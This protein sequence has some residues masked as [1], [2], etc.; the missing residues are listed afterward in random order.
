M[1]FVN[2]RELKDQFHLRLG[3][4][5]HASAQLDFNVGLSMNW[6][7]PHNEIDVDAV[8]KPNNS[9]KNRLEK[10]HELMRLTFDPTKP[11]IAKSF[12]HVFERAD[13]VRALRN[14]YLHGR[15][16]FRFAQDEEKP[17]VL[18]LALNWNMNPDQVD[19]SFKV[20]FEEFDAQIAEVE[21]VSAQ[22]GA[23]L[24]KYR[25]RAAPAAWYA[26]K[27]REAG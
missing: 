5:A 13:K 14:D 9:L 2:P 20:T 27:Q 4:L 18:F 1:P 7:G 21:A 17:H 10:L 8:L 22:L 3:R 23:L 15:W 11:E 6:L 19:A 24:H 12:A 25:A 26:Q 16:G